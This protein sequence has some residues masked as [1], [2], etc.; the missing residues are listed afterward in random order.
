MKMLF[1]TKTYP[2]TGHDYYR[3]FLKYEIL[4]ATCK[5]TERM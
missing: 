1:A 3:K 4:M 2:H 5:K